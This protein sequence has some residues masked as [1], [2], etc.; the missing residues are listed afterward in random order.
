MFSSPNFFSIRSLKMLPKTRSSRERSNNAKISTTTMIKALQ[1]LKLEVRFC[2][3]KLK[4]L[5]IF[6]EAKLQV[7]PKVTHVRRTWI[8]SG[9]PHK[10]QTSR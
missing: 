10:D 2:F 8:V 6:E 7:C 5:A 4:I 9:P 1:P 3:V